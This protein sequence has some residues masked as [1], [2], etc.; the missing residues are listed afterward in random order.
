MSVLERLAG[1]L[2]WE[3]REPRSGVTL[4]LIPDPDHPDWPRTVRIVEGQLTRE[5]DGALLAGLLDAWVS[6]GHDAPALLFE[7]APESVDVSALDHA[8]GYVSARGRDRIPLALAA[9]LLA[10]LEAPAGAGA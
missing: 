2:G 4:Y 10:A 7:A 3:R 5:S 1:A 8:D 6:M 9:A